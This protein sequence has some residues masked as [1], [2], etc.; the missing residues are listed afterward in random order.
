VE[1]VR[2]MGVHDLAAVSAQSGGTAIRQNRAHVVIRHRAV[3]STKRDGRQLRRRDTACPEHRRLPTTDIG[4]CAARARYTGRSL[5]SSKYGIVR[6][7]LRSYFGTPGQIFVASLR[8]RSRSSPVSSCATTGTLD[9]RTHT[10]A[11]GVCRRFRTQS[12]TVAIPAAPP[13]TMN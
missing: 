10:A 11:L 1:R 6:P 5:V 13:P 3:S 8:A 2:P 9:L 4:T 7:D 12:G